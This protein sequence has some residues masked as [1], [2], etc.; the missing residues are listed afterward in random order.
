MENSIIELK[1]VTKKFSH[2]SHPTL[3]CLDLKIE[4]EKITFILGL[5][6]TGKSVTLKHMIGLMSPDSGK[7]WVQGQDLNTLTV[8]Q[9]NQTRRTMGYVF[10]HAALFD[11]M[12][13][14]ENVA[15]PLREFSGKSEA[16]IKDLVARNL[17]DVG[18]V[19]G[20]GRLPSELSGGQ[21]KRV[22]LARTLVLQPR[23]LLYDEPTTGLDPIMCDVLDQLILK[24]GKAQKRTSVVI[25]HDLQACYKIADRVAVLHKGRVLEYGTVEQI[26]NSKSE[27]VQAFLSGDSRHI[28]RWI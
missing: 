26:K 19:E 5:S 9:L 13:V 14:F 17:A 1:K 11:S 21:R 6:G 10:Q 16:E 23:I 3:D 4:A 12:T 20:L 22:G 7:V 27:F 15:F 18:I 25:S 28:E 8:A 24:F 2:A